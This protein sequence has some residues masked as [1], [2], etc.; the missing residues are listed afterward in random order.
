MYQHDAKQVAAA[1]AE[2]YILAI[3]KEVESLIPLVFEPDLPSND[4]PFWHPFEHE[5]WQRGEEIRQLLNVHK[6]LRNKDNILDKIFE[7][8]INR[9]LKKGRQSF[10][11]LLGNVDSKRYGANLITQ[12]D[13]RCVYGHIIDAVYKMKLPEFVEAIKPYC[14][15]EEAWI[16]NKAKKYIEKYGN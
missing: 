14:D 8:S 4:V 3:I 5:I 6:K 11:M 10:I 15:D 1:K 7:V 13:D 9:R 2:K 12:L 16:R